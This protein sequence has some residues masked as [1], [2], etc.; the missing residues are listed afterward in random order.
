MFNAVKTVSVRLISC[1]WLLV[2]YGRRGLSPMLCRPWTQPTSKRRA[3]YPQ[4]KAGPL[5]LVRY[6]NGVILLHDR[7]RPQSNKRGGRS[8]A[9]PEVVRGLSWRRRNYTMS[10]GLT[11]PNRPLENVRIKCA[12][13]HFL[14]LSVWL[15]TK[16]I[17]VLLL[18]A[19]FLDL[20]RASDSDSA[21][22]F[23]ASHTLI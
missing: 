3:A 17:H 10:A 15:Q 12:A 1:V 18:S 5:R 13:A 21:A 11:T 20:E 8:G 2:S 14:L 4:F 22:V 16:V 7:P 23:S 9:D 6:C 19:R